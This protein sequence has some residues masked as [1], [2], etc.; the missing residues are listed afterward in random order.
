MTLHGFFTLVLILTGAAGAAAQEEQTC[1]DPLSIQVFLDRRGFSPGEIDANLGANT[2]RALAA[3]QE[4][5]ALPANG[6]PDCATWKALDDGQPVTTTYT[7]TDDD[8]KAPVQPKIPAA[9]PEQ[10]SLPSLEYRSLQER[11][12][13]R[14]HV[15]PALLAKLNPGA[16]LTAGASITVPG[17]TPFDAVKKPVRD[18]SRPGTSVVVSREGWMRVLG[19][20]G[21]LLFFAPVTSGSEHDPLP[22]GEWKVTAVAW[23]PP[24]HYNP[25]LFWDAKATDEKATLKPGPNNPVGVVWIDLSLE[26]YGLHGTPEPGKVGHTQSHGCV[27]LTNWDAARVAALVEPGTTVTFK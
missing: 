12:S 1:L 7:I 27:R 18:Q 3:F 17:V 24:F 26:H 13:E 19:A 4:A 14:F 22:P 23:R 25:D 16:A 15:S 8:A 5:N 2:K 10:A 6:T 21:A 20:D 11:I 9:L